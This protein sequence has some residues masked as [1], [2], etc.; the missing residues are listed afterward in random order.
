MRG[1]GRVQAW[2][3]EGRMKVKA[4]PRWEGSCRREWRE[5]RRELAGHKAIRMAW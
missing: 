3:K 4:E 5:G 1:G 2:A